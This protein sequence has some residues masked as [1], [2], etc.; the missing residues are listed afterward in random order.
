MGA[1]LFER[2][3][4]RCDVIAVRPRHPPTDR[5]PFIG[6]GLA[7]KG[8]AGGAVGLLIVHIDDGDQIAQVPMRGG[9]S[10]LP[11]RTFVQLAVGHQVVDEGGILL[12]FQAKADSHRDCQAVAQ[13]AA[14]D[15]HT[16][17]VMRHA[18]HRLSSAP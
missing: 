5:S 7:A 14:G 12:A 11:G 17:F 18:R 1:G 13:R 16:R 10:G 8:L 4:N 6:Q 3:Q 15:F 9:Q 2:A